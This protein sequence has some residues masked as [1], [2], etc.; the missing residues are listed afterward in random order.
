M[1]LDPAFVADCLYELDG[2]MIDEVLTVDMEK[3]LVRVRM[4]THENL[5]ITVTQRVK[6][7]LHPRHISGGLMVHMTGVAAFAH[8]YYVLGL[9]HGEGWTGYGVRIQ[10]ARFHKLGE[11][12]PP[13]ILECQAMHVRR[14][15]P[16][17]L[18]RY[19]FRF[20]Q[21][22]VL[23]YEGKQTALWMKP[24]AESNKTSAKPAEAV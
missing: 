1:P 7:D 17:M 16:N 3:S 8:F 15:H 12:G 24:G 13:L 22:D 18:V 2:L 21:E 19:E 14:M 11:I 4:P 20:T 10:D 5:P 23:V 6:G 9:R